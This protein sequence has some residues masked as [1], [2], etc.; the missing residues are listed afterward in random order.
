[1]FPLQLRFGGVSKYVTHPL[2]RFCVLRVYVWLLPSRIFPLYLTSWQAFA[3]NLHCSARGSVGFCDN[4]PAYVV[5]CEL[6]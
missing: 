6:Y 3:H 2:C 4:R 5:L 1:M